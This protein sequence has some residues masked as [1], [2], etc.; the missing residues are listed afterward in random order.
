MKKFS[1]VV[2]IVAE[3][4]DTESVIH[5]LSE[6]LTDALPETVYA[7]VKNNGVKEFSVQGFK[8]WR[9]RV[10][11]VDAKTAGDAHNSKPVKVADAAP[12]DTETAAAE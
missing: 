1:I 4:L 11:G 9:A 6:C 8:V 7:N 3:A 5:S 10:A 2:D 12:A